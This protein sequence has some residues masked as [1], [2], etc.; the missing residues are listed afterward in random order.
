[1]P[2]PR[3]AGNCYE[4]ALLFV[5]HAQLATLDGAPAI[6]GLT[7]VHGILRRPDGSQM[8]HGWI[9][10]DGIVY[11]PETGRSTP[12]NLD[13]VLARVVYRVSYTPE[14]AIEQAQQSGH[15]G[16]WDQRISG[17]THADDCL[18]ALPTWPGRDELQD[19]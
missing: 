8:G 9:E 6:P 7:L 14:H 12:R 15:Y 18:S 3:L 17:A 5:L 11:E 1:M 4:Q 16:P 2:K 10:Q 13:Y 19:G